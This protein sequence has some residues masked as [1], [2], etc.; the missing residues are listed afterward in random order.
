M[1]SVYL[2]QIPNAS[3]WQ[4]EHLLKITLTNCFHSILVVE[5][6]ES[7]EA[8]RAELEAKV[9]EQLTAAQARAEKLEALAEV[10]LVSKAGDEGKLFGSIGTRDIADAIAAV[11]LEVAKSEVRLP[12]GTIRETGEFA[13]AIQLHS[14]VTTTINVIV[15]A[16]A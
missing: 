2:K 3:K 16:E 9:A 13:V 1:H 5:N 6:V 15:I 12:N 8:R 7:F 14:E 10:T 4:E 11:G